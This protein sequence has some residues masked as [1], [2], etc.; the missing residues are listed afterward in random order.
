MHVNGDGMNES[1]PVGVKKRKENESD[2][3][4][5]VQHANSTRK[6]NHTLTATHREVQYAREVFCGVCWGW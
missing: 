3:I 5:S 1:Q 4:F 2:R 6:Y